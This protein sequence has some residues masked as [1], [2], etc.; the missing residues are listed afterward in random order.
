MIKSLKVFIASC[1]AGEVSEGAIRGMRRTLNHRASPDEYCAV[2]DAIE[3]HK[4]RVS[5]AQM[6]K[7]RAWLLNNSLTKAGTVRKNAVIDGWRVDVAREA[8]AARLVGLEDAAE[9]RGA[10]AR[11]D[12]HPIYRYETADGRFFDYAPHSWQSGLSSRRI[13][14][15]VRHAFALLL[16][17]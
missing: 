9:Y 12:V 8:I 7:G 1:V 14:R 4:P 6:E 5:A 10:Y 2:A 3:K 17:C 13:V 16:H 11:T 15:R